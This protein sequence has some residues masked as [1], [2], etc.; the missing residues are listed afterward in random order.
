MSIHSSVSPRFSGGLSAISSAFV[1][2]LIV[3]SEIKLST[4]YHRIVFGMCCVDIIGSL[5]CSLASLPMP[6]EFPDDDWYDTWDGTRLGNTRTCEAQGFFST[7]GL[8]TMFAYNSML[9][10]T[11][12]FTLPRGCQMSR[13]ASTSNRPFCT[14]CHL[15]LD[16][17]QR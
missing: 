16:L 2:Y 8:V 9:C 4:I 15:R 17:G 10:F 14:L 13:F 11:T 3:R 12:L 7:F 5:A 1:I 6:T